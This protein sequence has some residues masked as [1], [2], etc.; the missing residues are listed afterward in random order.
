MP[1]PVKGFSTDTKSNPFST[2]V[3]LLYPLETL[4]RKL[5]KKVEHWLKMA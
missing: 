1:F 3:S 2:R 5:G 4:E